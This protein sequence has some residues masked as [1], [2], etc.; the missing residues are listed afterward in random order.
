[1]GFKDSYSVISELEL[2]GVIF[3]YSNLLLRIGG[4]HKLFQKGK[5]QNKK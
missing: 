3:N 4:L 2:K 1:M 5:L